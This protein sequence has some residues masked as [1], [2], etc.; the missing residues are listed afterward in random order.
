MQNLDEGTN[1]SQADSLLAQC[2]KHGDKNGF[3]ALAKTI[4]T[5]KSTESDSD[6]VVEHSVLKYLRG[7]YLRGRHVFIMCKLIQ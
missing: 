3:T 7:K 6:Y 1:P 5:S 4:G 2:N